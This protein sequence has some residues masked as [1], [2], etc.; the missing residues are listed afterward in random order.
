M[1]K[2]ICLTLLISLSLSAQADT[3]ITYQGQLQQ[4]GEAFTGNPRMEF[5]LFDSRSD[6]NQIGPT[7]SK[8]EVPVKDGLFQVALDFGSGAFDG[9]PRF[10]EIVIHPDPG[11]DGPGVVLTP[12]QHVS[13]TPVAVHAIS[14]GEDTLAELSCDGDQIARFDGNDWFCSDDIDTTYTA[15]TGLMLAGTEFEIDTGHTDGRYWRLGGNVDTDPASNFLGTSDDTPFEIHVDGEHAL[16]LEPSDNFVRGSIP[17]VIGGWSGNK[18]ESNISGATIGG[19]GCPD[20]GTTPCA[21]DDNPNVVT[22]SFGT[23]G[24]GSNNIASHE[25]TIGGGRRNNATGTLATIGGGSSNEASYGGA[26]VG[27]GSTNEASNLHATVAGGLN[28]EASGIR[29]TVPGGRDNEASG[30]DSFAAGRRA[31]AEHHGTFVWADSTDAD[32][33][34]TDDDQFLIEASGGVGIGS[35]NPVGA[36]HLRPTTTA[37]R[38]L[39]LQN[40]GGGSGTADSGWGLTTGWNSDNLNFYWGEDIFDSTALLSRINS[41]TGD[42]E[43]MSDRQLKHNIISIEGVIDRVMDLRPVRYQFKHAG[44]DSSVSFGF[45]AQEVEEVFPE[46]VSSFEGETNVLGLSYSNFSAVAIQAIRELHELTTDEL[47]Q[48]RAENAEMREQIAANSELAKRNVE[49]ED[50]LAKLEALLLEDRQVA[51]A[52]Q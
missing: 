50:R 36:L 48:L 31:K 24:G 15:G 5:R 20:V 7:I 39:I 6:D 30:N 41:D 3:T 38:A 43:V 52:E 10:I 16:R 17:N 29:A 34:S 33:A 9:T 25:A 32:F 14:G 11:V 19:G 51:G 44:P 21:S 37:G 23:I 2:L 13:A 46:F 42:Y 47:A 4:E 8:S 28:N 40:S 18:V 45:I 27:G 12:R 1:L 49:L 22:G 35:N 26:T